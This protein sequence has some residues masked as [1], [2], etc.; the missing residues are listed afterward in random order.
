MLT[1]NNPDAII[2]V[3]FATSNNIPADGT[4]TASVTAQVTDSAGAG[5]SGQSVVFTATAGALIGS[6]VITDTSGL[7]TTTLTST[8]AGISS[9]TAS[10]NSSAGHVDIT[11]TEPALSPVISSL[12]SDKDSIVND[13]V[14]KATLVATVT[15]SKTSEPLS[16][17]TVHWETSLGTLDYNQQATGQYGQSLVTLS[18]SMEVGTTTITAYLDNGSRS[19]TL[20]T[21]QNMPTSLML[22][23]L[24][25]Y[26]GGSTTLEAGQSIMLCGPIGQWHWKSARPGNN[27]LFCHTLISDIDTFDYR[28]YRDSY[29]I[30]DVPNLAD[31]FPGIITDSPVLGTALTI[32]DI[33][34]RVRLHPEDISHPV[35]AI[36]RQNYPSGLTGQYLCTSNHNAI[37]EPGV[38]LTLNKYYGLT[39]IPLQ[40]GIMDT[41]NGHTFT[42]TTTSLIATWNEQTQLP[43]VVLSND[44][45]NGW[46]LLPCRST[47]KAGEFETTLSGINISPAFNMYCVTNAPSSTLQGGAFNPVAFYGFPG[48]SI[49]V[50]V[51]G[52]ASILTE[53]PVV[54]DDT[55]YGRVD[56]ASPEA[57]VI[58][59]TAES[60]GVVKEDTM[61]FV[62]SYQFT[63]GGSLQDLH[64]TATTNVHHY[65]LTQNA[66]AD[67]ITPNMIFS[68]SM[69]TD[70]SVKKISINGKAFFT[71]D[72]QVYN[73]PFDSVA[74]ID[75]FDTSAESVTLS[76]TSSSTSS[77]GKLSFVP[78]SAI[79]T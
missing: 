6:P 49:T 79:K 10:V 70:P 64:T 22:Y 14:D 13:G 38:L 21:I 66:P 39:T 8:T 2:S 16:G 19:T 37:S 77:V 69:K 59:V 57:E 56:I 1:E 30:A 23:E 60:L 18:D 67:G 29:L 78:L 54:L 25:D 27:H 3:V 62:A 58:T 74:L 33:V 47:D 7:A 53:N 20:V 41:A 5:L 11:F 28:T 4:S 75:L 55:G 40:V 73:A 61:T 48:Q 65:Q 72:T 32:D 24:V 43:D 17:V 34:I 9:V 51:T 15:D 42:V 68:K 76:E 50:S 26:E 44:A 31:D 36:A 12:I 71:N 52:S 63:C 45:P 35:V 46:Q